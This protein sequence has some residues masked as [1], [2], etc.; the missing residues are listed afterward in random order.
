MA[1][2]AD[3]RAS[4][5][6]MLA[7]SD[8][9]S[10]IDSEIAR[11]VEHYNRQGGH[12]FTEE[13]GGTITTAANVAWYDQVDFPVY[14]P[15]GVAALHR[16]DHA[17][18]SQGWPLDQVSIAAFEDQRGSTSVTGTPSHFTRY[19]GRIGFWPT[20]AGAETITL[21]ARFQ[22]NVPDSDDD[23]SIW[24]MQAR[25]AI[26]SRVAAAVALKYLADPERAQMFT[27]A[28]EAADR[29]LAIETAAQTTTGRIRP[30]RF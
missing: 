7:R 8:L 23:T 30:T 2:R 1:T 15:V 3:I 25:E 29:A 17:R 20:P 5:A 27:V 11:A 6:D 9:A 18:A 14:G 19:G 24:F 10:Q 22:A 21:A 16:I 4:V 13:H 28:R 12:V 26:E